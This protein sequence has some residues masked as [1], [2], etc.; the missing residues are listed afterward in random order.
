MVSVTSKMIIYLASKAQIALLLFEKITIPE[1]Y[2]NF[3]N[4]FLKKSARVLL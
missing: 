4:V 3:A 1:K 2:L